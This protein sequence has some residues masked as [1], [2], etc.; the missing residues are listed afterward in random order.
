MLLLP[1]IQQAVN[2]GTRAEARQNCMIATIAAYRY[3]LQHGELPTSLADL[4]DFIPGDDATK[5]QRLT[6]P[7]DGQPLRFKSDSG[8]I[9]IYS[10]GIN[11]LDDGGVISNEKPQVGD[12]GYSIHN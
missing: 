4:K 11:R 9:V 2:A 1:A 8:N 6:D 10:I 7:Y 3:R 5:N 12:L